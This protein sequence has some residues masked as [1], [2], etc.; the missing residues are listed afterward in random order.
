MTNLVQEPPATEPQLKAS[1]EE[2][3]K[4]NYELQLDKLA[5]EKMVQVNHLPP[6]QFSRISLLLL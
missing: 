4:A 2:A 5:R 6:S 1:L 3:L